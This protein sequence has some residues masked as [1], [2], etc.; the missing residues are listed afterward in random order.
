MNP[1]VFHLISGDA[2]FTGIAL[3][4]L[5]VLATRCSKAI[6]R[7]STPLLLFAGVLSVALSST[8]I[9]YW[10]YA[11]AV[12]FSLLAFARARRTTSSRAWA[13]AVILVWIGLVVVEVPWRL[14]PRLSPVATRSL[15]I[16]G[17]SVTAGIGE[18]DIET[19]PGILARTHQIDVQDLSR[20]GATVGSAD[21]SLQGTIIRAE[22][23]LLEI[24][25]N[26][27]LGSTS[28]ADFRKNLNDL[29]QHVGSPDRQVVMFE[30]P[31]PPFYNEYGR[32]QRELAA[33]HGVKLIPRRV[34]LSI[35]SGGGSTLDS[36]H[37]SQS[38][39]RAMAGIVWEI[40][41]PAFES[42]KGNST[43][44]F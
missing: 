14:T 10:Y 37:L 26:D 36:I 24:G 31:L 5:G 3:I 18:G 16:I 4:V 21:K 20:M 15:T 42:A 1:I 22:L 27:L 44:L 43:Q 8:A 38:G 30:L 39:H 33:Q 32:I 28:T 35:L 17:D 19:W 23:V 11:G 25:G 41:G 40:V 7:R 29:L 6:V 34:F 13:A 9:P 12:A 2:F